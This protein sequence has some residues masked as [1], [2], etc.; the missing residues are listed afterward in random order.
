MFYDQI[1]KQILKIFEIMFAPKFLFKKMFCEMMRNWSKKV[2]WFRCWRFLQTNRY[3][4]V[5]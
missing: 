2:K 5:F 3:N 4:D 1:N